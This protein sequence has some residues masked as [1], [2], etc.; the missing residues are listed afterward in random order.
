MQGGRGWVTGEAEAPADKPN[1]IFV[2]TDDLDF[3]SIEKMPEI[4]SLLKDKGVSFEDAFISHP[5]CCPSRSTIL[6]GLYD[7]NH[8][9]RGNRPPDGGFQKF[10]SEGHEENTIAVRLQEGGYKTAF[11]GKYLNGYT[12]EDPTHVPPGWDEWYGKL[13]EQ[14][15][16][17]YSIN[18]N[19]EEVSYG[20]ETG[21]FFTDVLSGKVTD[22]I[23]QAAPEDQPFFAYVAPTAPHGPATPAERH[24]GAFADEEAPRPPSF[25]EED[26]SDKPAWIRNSNPLSEQDISGIDSRYQ[27]RLESVLAVDEMVGSLVEELKAAGELDNTYIFFTSDNGFEQ[28]EHRIR[29]GKD[30]PYEESSRVPLFVR[31]PGVASGT[32]LENLAVNT[33]FA[34][35]FAELAGIDFPAD[36]RSL[37]P[38]LRGE[39][40]PWRSAILIERLPAED[41]D[42]ETSGEGKAKGKGKMGGGGSPP[43]E[44]IRTDAY[45]YIEYGNGEKELY[46]LKEDPYEIESLH[47]S[48]DPSLLE[49]LKARLGALEGCSG[50]GCREDEDVP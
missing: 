50:E 38:L 34:P 24:K 16:Y 46:D 12:A 8:N 36:G 33:D 37:A 14:E 19:G 26:V 31:G 7:H 4:N 10:V 41:G 44:A 17:D 22:F 47:E 25:N 48:A 3:A 1:I 43:Y 40:P 23:G 28:G 20:N 18:E 5:L 32:E 42:E 29:G 49:D 15:L 35:T 27:K 21:D 11:F 39:V 2:L 30:R 6:T 45:K 13:Q 9:V